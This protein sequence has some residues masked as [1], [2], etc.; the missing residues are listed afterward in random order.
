[1]ILSL[2]GLNCDEDDRHIF[3][4]TLINFYLHTLNKMSIL[5]NTVCFCLF[6]I[7]TNTGSEYLL[8]AD[9]H[10]TASKW[11][12]TIR[13]TID[14]SVRTCSPLN[15]L[16]LWLS[17]SVLT[18]FCSLENVNVHPSFSNLKKSPK[19][20]E[21]Q[22]KQRKTESVV[23]EPPPPRRLQLIGWSKSLP[24]P[25]FNSLSF[26]TKAEGGFPLQRSN[27][28]E[29]LP[30]HSSLPGH[31]SASPIAKQRNQANRRSISE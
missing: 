25:G 3:F 12:D 16:S 8:Q 14:S 5:I 19:P 28:S 26:Q 15:R 22:S 21:I 29:Y 31:G 4:K 2:L 30:R 23:D 24:L 6:Q 1:M 10:P 11:Y 27:S 13:K 17:I 18:L 7:T 9:S 20:K